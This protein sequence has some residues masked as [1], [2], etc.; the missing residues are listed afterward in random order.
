MSYFRVN[1][2]LT[3]RFWNWDGK[4]NRKRV[5]DQ[6]DQ[7]PLDFSELGPLGKP[8]LLLNLCWNSKPKAAV[9]Q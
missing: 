9:I 7:C 5:F 4:N 2:T 3:D 1:L 8:D 6:L